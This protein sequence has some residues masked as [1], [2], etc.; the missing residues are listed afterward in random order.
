MHDGA[1]GL[2]GPAHDVVAILEVD[3]EDFG[4]SAAFGLLPYAD[5][6][7]GFESARVEANGLLLC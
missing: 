1:V 3:D 7:V 6:V 2:D 5:K 4:L